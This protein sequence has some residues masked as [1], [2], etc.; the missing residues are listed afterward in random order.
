MTTRTRGTSWTGGGRVHYRERTWAPL[1]VMALIWV[2]CGAAI[3]G[4]VYGI[5][6]S[7]LSVTGDQGVSWSGISAWAGAG[8]GAFFLFAINAFFLRLDV[9]V[10]SDHVFIAFGPVHLIRKRI[11]F[12]DIEE[13]RGLTYRPLLEFGGWGIRLRPGKSAWTIRG[14]Q[15]AAV[16]LAGGKQVYVGTRYPQRLAGAISTAMRQAS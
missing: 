1:W 2:A 11:H 15:A 16:T 5:V 3:I 14:N 4:A 9:E 13:V 7:G 8:V 6:E 12:S 10:R